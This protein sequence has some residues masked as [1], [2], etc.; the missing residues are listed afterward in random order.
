[1]I[2]NCEFCNSD[3][4]CSRS[5]QRFCSLTCSAS[6]P[7]NVDSDVECAVC[8][9]IFH[10]SPS[11]I[12]ASKSGLFFCSK[13]HKNQAQRIGGIRE[14]MPDHYGKTSTDYRS[15]AFRAYPQ[16]CNQCGYN[17]YSEVLVV[18]HKDLNHQN[19]DVSNLEILCPTHH[20][21]VHH[22]ARSNWM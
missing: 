6:R 11:A 8:G 10:K 13:E 18:H 12:K 2:K 15:I 21:E 7:K 9:K 3:F 16:R 1:M 14:I 19:N 17:K 4:E 22:L 5:R 20:G